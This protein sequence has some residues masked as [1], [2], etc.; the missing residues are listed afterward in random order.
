MLMKPTYIFYVFILFICFSISIKSS[1]QAVSGFLTIENY[2]KVKW[3]YAEEFIHLWKVN[4][5]PLLKKAMEN[6]DIVSVEARNPILHGGEDTR[7]DFRVIIVFRDAKAAFDQ[8]LLDPYKKLLYPDSEKLKKE[9]EHRFSLLL[10]HWDV[11]SE[12]VILP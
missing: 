3:G 11:I 1:A 12:P 5:Y 2:Y 9:E 10:A 4:H 7:W 6:K 8:K